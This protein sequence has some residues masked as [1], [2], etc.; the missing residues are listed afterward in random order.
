MA[1]KV[2]LCSRALVLIGANPI[3]SFN[4][5]TT[6]S[7]SASHLYD[8]VVENELSSYPWSFA[9]KQEQL[10]RLTTNP[11]ANYNSAYQVPADCFRI[12]QVTSGNTIQ[13]FRR[14]GDVIHT[15]AGKSDKLFADY[16]ASIAIEEWPPYFRKMILY[17]LASTF[18]L[19]VAQQVDLSDY[20]AKTA[21]N[22]M[23]VA[24]QADASAQTNR[25]VRPRNL[26][27]AR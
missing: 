25:R 2:E 9:K 24:K 6:E 22:Q 1:T 11:I 10:S 7:D 4:D 19:S 3:N 5:N 13:D 26:Y 20:M 21:M 23:R 12:D 18:A 15:N 16:T 27:A 14:I 17:K 8:E